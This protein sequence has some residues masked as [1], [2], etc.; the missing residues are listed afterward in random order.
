MEQLNP[1]INTLDIVCHSP[2]AEGLKLTQQFTSNDF[3]VAGGQFL[4]YVPS[5]F[6]GD[7]N[8][9]KFTFENLSSKYMDDTYG[10]GTTGNARNYLVKSPYYNTYGDGKQ[11]TTTGN[12][13]A[14]DKVRSEMC[15]DQAFKYNNAADLTNTGTASTAATLEEYPYS[16]TLYKSQGGTFTEDIEIA[17][18]EEKPCYLFTGDE[19]RYNIAPTTALE[20][21]FYAYYLMDIQL[22]TKDYEAKCVL[23]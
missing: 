17:V 10:K 23:T 20:H 11:Y 12:E 9:C 1:F 13:S 4:F 21:R 15:G 22:L 6:V 7:T 5:D 3:Q 16:E 18:N 8:K 2:K 14:D 19:T